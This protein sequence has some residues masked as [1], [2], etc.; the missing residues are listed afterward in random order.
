[1][2]FI[3]IFFFLNLFLNFFLNLFLNLFL[4]FIVLLII[5][6]FNIFIKR[7][8]FLIIIGFLINHMINIIIKLYQLIWCLLY[9]WINKRHL[10]WHLLYLHNRMENWKLLLMCKINI[11]L[12][13]MCNILCF[14]HSIQ[15]HFRCFCVFVI[16]FKYPISK[17][18]FVL[19]GNKNIYLNHCC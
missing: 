13:L 8:V 2:I 7:I 15:K 10:K 19:F 11:L 14:F 17:R 5:N 12:H 1:M 9:H 16:L 4:N 3:I 6:I 18:K